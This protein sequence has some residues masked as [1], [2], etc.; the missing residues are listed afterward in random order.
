MKN[1]ITSITEKVP[2]VTI[3]PDGL[4]YGTWGGSVIDITYK[5]KKYELITEEGV[6]GSGFKVAVEI[7]DGVAT[8]DSVQ[9]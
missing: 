3:L 5:E 1:K 9:S 8:F 6:R 4:Y 2:Q 7:K